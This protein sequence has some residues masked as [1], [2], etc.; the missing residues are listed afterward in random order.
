[1]Q[2]EVE[3]LHEVEVGADAAHEDVDRLDVAMDEAA[4]MRLAERVTYLSQQIHHAIGLHRSEHVDE[5]FEADAVQE[6]HHVVEIAVFGHAEVVHVDGV[7]RSERR[8]SLG[9]ALDPPHDRLAGTWTG[10]EYVFADQFDRGRPSQ[11]PMLGAPHFPHAA[12][13]DRL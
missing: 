5:P 8:L 12:F 10:P 1:D 7:R 3:H 6:L 11:Q 4:V 9:S 2:A 13:A